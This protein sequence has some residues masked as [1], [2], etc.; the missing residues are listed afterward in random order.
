MTMTSTANW[1]TGSSPHENLMGRPMSLPHSP[2]FSVKQALPEP[3][4]TD[5]HNFK[6]GD[7]VYVRIYKRN[8]SLQAWWCGPL[9]I[10]LTTHTAVKCKGKAAWIHASHCKLAHHPKKPRVERYLRVALIVSLVICVCVLLT[11]ACIML[12]WPTW[13]FISTYDGN[14]LYIPQPNAC[15]TNHQ[16]NRIAHRNRRGVTS[17][18]GLDKAS[19][20]T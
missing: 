12:I 13:L 5:Y 10:L 2:P 4:T 20:R 8:N 16:A 19:N 11:L 18:V 9:L 7:L 1:K 15:H 14:Y 6:P 17:G 3:A